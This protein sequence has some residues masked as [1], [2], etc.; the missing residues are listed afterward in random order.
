VKGNLI[1]F[2]SFG[3]FR[4]A[5]LTLLRIA[6]GCGTLLRA[7]QVALKIEVDKAMK[8]CPRCGSS[9]VDTTTLCP[10]DGTPLEREGDPLIGQVL[11]GKYRIEE[12]ISEGGMGLVYRATHIFMD[13]VLAV[14]VLH[15]SLGPFFK[16]S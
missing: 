12:R 15:P 13:R 11:A 10:T 3:Y 2:T 6:G 14:K 8:R 16:R 9:Y 7:P 5:K 4:P 1:P